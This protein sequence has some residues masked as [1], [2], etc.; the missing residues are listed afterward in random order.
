[1][2]DSPPSTLRNRDALRA[3]TEELLE[4]ESD[5]DLKQAIAESFETAPGNPQSYS[6]SRNDALRDYESTN[7][8]VEEKKLQKQR[9][10]ERI[11]AERYSR[12][13]PTGN[14]ASHEDMNM[15][16][17]REIWGPGTCLFC[18]AAII[19]TPQTHSHF[20]PN[21]SSE[22]SKAASG[23]HGTQESAMQWAWL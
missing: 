12:R 19:S 13:N 5:R 18:L 2:A 4:L 8:R 11:R 7:K 1:M 23:V 10:E 3:L 14:S 16:Q 21:S 20:V 22:L 6:D 9:L 15:W 17:A